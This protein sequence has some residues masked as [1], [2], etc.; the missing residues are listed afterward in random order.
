MEFPKITRITGFFEKRK[1]YSEDTNIQIGELRLLKSGSKIFSI[2]N[3]VEFITTKETIIKLDQPI[4][5][6]PKFYF[7]KPQELL[8]ADMIPTL[9]SK[10][11]DEWEINI[12]DTFEYVLPESTFQKSLKK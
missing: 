2:K 10:G 5:W 1:P 9:I 11:A 7:A 3:Q 4:I 12:E 8:F 6:N